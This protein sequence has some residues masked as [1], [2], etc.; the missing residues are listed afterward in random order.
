VEQYGGNIC[1]QL[2]RMGTSADWSRQVDQPGPAWQGAR[3]GALPGGVACCARL[4]KQSARI[5]TQFKT[6]ARRRRSRWT[7]T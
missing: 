4:V 2:R 5:I 7:P 3:R 6:P 1:A